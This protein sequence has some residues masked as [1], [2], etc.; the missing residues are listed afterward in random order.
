MPELFTNPLA[1]LA[2]ICLGL[3]ILWAARH[4]TREETEWFQGIL[5]STDAEL[6]ARPIRVLDRD[7]KRMG[8]IVARTHQLHG[9]TPSRITEGLAA[10][11]YARLVTALNVAARAF[12]T[13]GDPK[14]VKRDTQVPV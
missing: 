11:Q 5:Q 6:T 13:E 10:E 3:L 8:D 2:L 7:R 4:V 1:L 12:H 14:L 9:I